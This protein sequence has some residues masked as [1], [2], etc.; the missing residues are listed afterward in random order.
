MFNIILVYFSLISIIKFYIIINTYNSIL[1]QK[2]FVF[3][4]VISITLFIFYINYNYNNYEFKGRI[5]FDKDENISNSTKI[6]LLIFLLLFIYN[7]IYSIILL[8]SN[9][10]F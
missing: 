4:T 3:N 10:I 7:F 8:I 6:I 2:L 9:H 1:F 5:S